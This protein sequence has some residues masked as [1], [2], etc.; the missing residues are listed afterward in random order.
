MTWLGLT[1]WVWMLI[2]FGFFWVMSVIELVLFVLL[3]ESI[4]LFTRLLSNRSRP[5]NTTQTSV[6]RRTFWGL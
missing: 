2:A 6:S 1:W 4:F 3:A 5:A